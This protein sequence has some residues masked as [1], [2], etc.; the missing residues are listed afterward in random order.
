MQIQQDYVM[1][2]AHYVRGTEHTVLAFNNRL[3]ITVRGRRQLI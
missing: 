2:M 3:P 1:A